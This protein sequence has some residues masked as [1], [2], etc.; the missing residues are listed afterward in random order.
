M[1]RAPAWQVVITSLPTC[2]LVTTIQLDQVSLF[3]SVVFSTE[4]DR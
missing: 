1:C 4:L 2:Q 3:Y